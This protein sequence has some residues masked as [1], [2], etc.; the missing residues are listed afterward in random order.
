MIALA[1]TSTTHEGAGK[2]AIHA[3]SVPTF[4]AHDL[5]EAHPPS[6]EEG[7]CADELHSRHHTCLNS[8]PPKNIDQGLGP[9]ASV[10]AEAGQG[11]NLLGGPRQGTCKVH[12]PSD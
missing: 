9:R 8:Q 3:V 5:M 11:V 6:Y 1:T 4:P 7:E 12:D 10:S 2:Y